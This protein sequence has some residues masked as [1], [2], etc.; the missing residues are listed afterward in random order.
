MKFS[1]IFLQPIGKIKLYRRIMKK[2][3]AL[4]LVLSL[5]FSLALVGCNNQSNQGDEEKSKI[6][7]ITKVELMP[8]F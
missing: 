7:I 2:L 1:N 5:I 4:I 6:I 8:T 3:L